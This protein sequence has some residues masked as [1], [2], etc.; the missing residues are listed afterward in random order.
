M[1][2]FIGVRISWLIVA[3]N[4]DLATLAA[5][6][7]SLA[8]CSDALAAS[9]SRPWRTARAAVSANLPDAR[10]KVTPYNAMST[11]SSVECNDS[12]SKVATNTLVNSGT[13]SQRNERPASDMKNAAMEI[14]PH[15]N[16]T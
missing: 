7:S 12:L 1:T 3:R 16:T 5:S 6:A 11:A 8:R 9:T 13:A 2:P 14:E 10:S 4:C 15:A